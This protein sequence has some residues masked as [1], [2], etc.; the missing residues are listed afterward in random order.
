MTM[1]EETLTAAALG[2]LRL[3]ARRLPQWSPHP[4][5]RHLVPSDPEWGPVT[6]ALADVERL[7]TAGDK[8]EAP[9]T[10]CEICVGEVD[11]CG[12]V[13]GHEHT[14]KP[15]KS[16]VALRAT[17]RPEGVDGNGRPLPKGTTYR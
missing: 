15:R 8:A 5:I 14:C 13:I 10:G 16:A 11:D 4:D 9:C 1:T 17:P 3:A 12:C 7:L 2:E 6:V